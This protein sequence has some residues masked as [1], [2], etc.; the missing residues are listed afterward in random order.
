MTPKKSE[1][2]IQLETDKQDLRELGDR[3]T[4]LQTQKS[5]NPG[6]DTIDWELRACNRLAVKLLRRITWLE[7]RITSGVQ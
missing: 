2:Q 7:Q 5:R 3:I 6:S 4:Y 1:D